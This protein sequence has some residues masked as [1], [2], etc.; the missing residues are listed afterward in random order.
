[1]ISAPREIGTRRVHRRGAQQDV[2]RRGAAGDPQAR[3][4]GRR[5]RA[6]RGRPAAGAA[7]PLAA[8]VA[9]DV[10]VAVAQ[11]V[12]EGSGVPVVPGQRRARR[13]L[14]RDDVVARRDEIRDAARRSPVRPRAVTAASDSGCAFAVVPHRTTVG[15]IRRSLNGGRSW[16]SRRTGR[17]TACRRSGCRSPCSPRRR[18]WPGWRRPATPSRCRYS[19]AGCR[20]RPR[21]GCRTSPR[22]GSARRPRSR[23]RRQCSAGPAGTPKPRLM[24]TMSAPIVYPSAVRAASRPTPSRRRDR[25]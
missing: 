9:I 1:M 4:S 7:L 20:S 2:R 19:P 21:R 12:G 17:P 15:S 23:R 10:P 18:P 22:A 24:L 5:R 25:C 16:A 14:R 3:P 6:R 8:G 11:R 13:R